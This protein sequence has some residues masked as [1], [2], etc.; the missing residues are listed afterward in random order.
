MSLTINQIKTLQVE[1]TTYCNAKCPHCPRF[2]ED[3]FLAESVTLSHWNIHQLINNLEIEKMTSL[4]RIIIEGDKGD[5]VMHPKLYE[6]LVYLS[7]APSQPVIELTTNGSIQTTKWWAK[8]AALP[9]LIVRFSIDGLKDTNHLYRVGV[10]FDKVTA[11]ATAFISAGGDALMKTLIFEHNEH[12]INEIIQFSKEMKFFA[13]FFAKGAEDRFLNLP[14][15]EVK[16]KGQI[17]HTI[18]PSQFSADVIWELSLYHKTLPRY[19]YVLKNETNIYNLICPNMAKGRLY[20]TYQHHVIPCCM[21]HNDLYLDYPSGRRL[22]NELVSDLESID[23]SKR[24][25]SD[26]LF[27]H[28]FNNRLENHFYSGPHLPVCVK[29]CKNRIKTAMEIRKNT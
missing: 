4:E 26:I 7:S 20:I 10:D 17:L 3:G 16:V 27:S 13:L 2:T 28:L 9:N 1:I 19:D 6:F 22:I 8:V 11:N 12:Q 18:K 24:K 14:V 15:W 21:M 25:I 5:P 29:S 23:L